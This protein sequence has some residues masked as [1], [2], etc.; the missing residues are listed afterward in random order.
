MDSLALLPK[1]KFMAAANRAMAE[2]D[3]KTKEFKRM[4]KLPKQQALERGEETDS[5]DN[6]DDNE[7]DDVV[8]ADIE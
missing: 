5:D 1:D 2:W 8:V 7:E 6:N 3:K 4:K